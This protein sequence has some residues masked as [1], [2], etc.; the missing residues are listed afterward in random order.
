LFDQFAQFPNLAEVEKLLGGKESYKGMENL[1]RA[2]HPSG[3]RVMPLSL[4]LVSPRTGCYQPNNHTL[5][6]YAER[7]YFFGRM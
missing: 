5:N 1:P 6:L 2:H 4:I 7:F 3:P